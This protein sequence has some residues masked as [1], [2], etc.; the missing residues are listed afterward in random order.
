MWRLEQP[1]WCS[2]HAQQLLVACRRGHAHACRCFN[3]FNTI[4]Q[5][6][7]TIEESRRQSPPITASHKPTP[8]TANMRLIVGIG[9]CQGRLRSISGAQLR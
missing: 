2:E 5:S 3:E 7:S 9:R 1:A 4:E 6:H 8:N